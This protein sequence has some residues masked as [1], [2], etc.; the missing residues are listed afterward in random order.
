MK[1]NSIPRRKSNLLI[2]FFYLI[3]CILSWELPIHR[4]IILT[5]FIVFLL[6]AFVKYTLVINHNII[7]T[8]QLFRI[9]IYKKEVTSLHIKEIIFKRRDWSSKLA[10]I[11]LYKGLSI[12]VAL[13]KPENVYDDLVE[14]CEDN[15]IHYEKTRDYK[16]IE[17]MTYA[18]K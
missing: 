3:L 13:F 18:S 6:L 16:I 10:V 8:I 11:K 2:A 9:T 14:F 15:A 7:Y 17:K 4:W 5:A 12:R 1:Y